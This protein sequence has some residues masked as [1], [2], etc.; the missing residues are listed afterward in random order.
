MFGEITEN[1]FC[2]CAHLQIKSIKYVVFPN[3]K[4]LV[5]LWSVLRFSLVWQLVSA[6]LNPI[7]LCLLLSASVWLL[8]PFLLRGCQRT[9]QKPTKALMCWQSHIKPLN[10]PRCFFLSAGHSHPQFCW[11][12]SNAAATSVVLTW[13]LTA[14]GNIFTPANMCI[15][16]VKFVTCVFICCWLFRATTLI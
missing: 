5:G 14:S 1:D 3:I 15:Y 11:R 12:T 4:K 6:S 2:V 8:V 10:K 13:H 16:R 7:L 9:Q